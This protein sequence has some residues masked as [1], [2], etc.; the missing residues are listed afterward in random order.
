LPHA[1]ELAKAFGTRLH[2]MTVVPPFGFAM[3]GQHFPEDYESQVMAEAKQRL[4]D[5]TAAHLPDGLT[6]QHIVGHGR[7]YDEILRM[8]DE[9]ACDLILM[10]SHRP[11]L[12]D[13]LLGPNAA[14][15][16]R[17]A[18]QSVL[19]VRDRPDGAPA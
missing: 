12:K 13:Y 10:A 4:H 6:V 8:A 16:V 5:F 15:V 17:H 11:E 18:K 19:V 2:I 9:A 7:I 14:R 1:V 3:V